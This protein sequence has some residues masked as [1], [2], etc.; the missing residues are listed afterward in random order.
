MTQKH[1]KVLFTALLI[2]IIFAFVF[3]IG[4]MG[5]GGRARGQVEQNLFY[6]VDFNSLEARSDLQSTTLLAMQLQNSRAIADPASV[7]QMMYRR[8]ISLY[9]A[10]QLQIPAPNEEQAFDY[11]KTLPAFRNPQTNQFDAVRMQQIVD[12]M[13]AQTEQQFKRV[14]EQQYRIIKVSEA[15]AGPSFAQPLEAELQLR[16]LQTE[17]DVTVASLPEIAYTAEIEVTDAALE[18]YYE[19]NKSRYEIAPKIQATYVLYPLDDYISKLETEPTEADLQ[20]HFEANRSSYTQDLLP[21]DVTAEVELFGALRNEVLNSW[22]REQA[23]P[24]ALKD[25]SMMTGDLYN[26]TISDGLEPDDLRDFLVERG[27]KVRSLKPVNTENPTLQPGFTRSAMRIVSK[28]SPDNFYSDPVVVDAGVAVFFYRDTLPSRYPEL[29]A[30]R[31]D[32]A[33]HYRADERTRRF[34]A[35]IQELATLLENA[36][37]SG[38]DF[39]EAAQ[40]KGLKIDT[41]D[42]VTLANPPAPLQLNYF[43]LEGISMMDEGEVT[44]PVTH[45]QTA[46]FVHAREKREPII[47]PA[48]E[49]YATALDQVGQNL[50]FTRT[51]ALYGELTE[52]GLRKAGLIETESAPQ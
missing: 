23:R 12:S 17:V 32:V 13:D 50:R 42:A 2:V 36:V 39:A 52:I 49:T 35:H 47:D 1:N 44:G 11:M 26:A 31:D 6:G 8:A 25:A 9:M 45:Q 7:E 46:Y 22:Q 24:L 33:S 29:T 37:A 15:M 5:S 28:L 48:S 4:N 30:I 43:L 40:A 14:I 10:N 34:Q 27:L 16:A 19:Q 21:E 20:A 51:T 38:D 41:Y 18:T 3:T